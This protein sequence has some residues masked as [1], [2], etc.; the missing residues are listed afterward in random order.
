P[1]IVDFEVAAVDVSETTEP[2]QK[3]SVTNTGQDD[4]VLSNIAIQGA[5][6]GVFSVVSPSDG[7]VT[8]G[9]RETTIIEVAFSPD[10]RGVFRAQITLESNAENLD[11]AALEL[12]GPAVAT[13]AGVGFPDIAAIDDPVT[14]FEGTTFGKVVDSNRAKGG[15]LENRYRI[16]TE[17]RQLPTWSRGDAARGIVCDEW[18]SRL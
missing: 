9:S 4:L 18:R 1:P 3:I 16:R 14:V 10:T 8:V 2:R 6:A 12:V 15:P 5:D 13:K 17:W 7:T 11:S